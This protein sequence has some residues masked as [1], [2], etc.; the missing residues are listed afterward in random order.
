MITQTCLRATCLAV[1]S[2]F[3][4]GGSVAS[5][6]IFTSTITSGNSAL[7]GSPGPYGTVT[8]NLTSPTMAT[9]TFA[10][11]TGFLFGDSGAADVNINATSF[12][13]TIGTLAG[14]FTTPTC[15]STGCFSSGNVDAQ[16]SFNLTTELFDGYTN[17][18]NSITFTVNNT[19]G[20]FASAADVL[21]ANAS[22]LDAAAHIFVCSDPTCSTTAG[23]AIATGFAGELGST[24]SVPEPGSIVFLCTTLLGAGVL[25]RR[26]IQSRQS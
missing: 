5:A 9:I 14:P 3:V 26:K 10:A 17:A 4:L 6:E 21:A 20:T 22:G 1:A 18:A 19:S 12:T 25:V 8:V 13:E 16:G 2:L 24:G 23:G 15:K 11:N 7:A